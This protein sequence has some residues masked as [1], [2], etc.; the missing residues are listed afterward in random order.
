MHQQCVGSGGYLR[1]RLTVSASD[2]PVRSAAVPARDQPVRSATGA[3]A[4]D[5]GR[6]VH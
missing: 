4:G 2:Q 1:R 3:S 6:A 5:R